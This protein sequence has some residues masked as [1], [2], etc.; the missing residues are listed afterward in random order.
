MKKIQI[1]ITAILLIIISAAG[2][3]YFTYTRTPQYSVIMILR[4]IKT[5]NWEM[6]QKY[7]DIDEVSGNLL[8][9]TGDFIGEFLNIN[10]SETEGRFKKKIAEKLG[11]LIKPKVAE[12]VKKG[13]EQFIK[14]GDVKKEPDSSLKKKLILN[15]KLT[16]EKQEGEMAIV[17]LDVKDGERDINIRL[18]MKKKDGYWQLVEILN[19]EEIIK[20]VI[21]GK[22]K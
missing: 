13:L 6:F 15:S 18:R 1:I 16:C 2:I 19:P 9:K 10:Q 14:E 5:H 22:M 12:E 8:D 17:S 7:V 4:S 3:Y 11:D 20:D 21:A